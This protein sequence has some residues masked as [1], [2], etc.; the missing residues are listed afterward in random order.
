MPVSCTS[1]PL[2]PK[3]N[4]VSSPTAKIQEPPKA[5]QNPPKQAVASIIWQLA[6]HITLAARRDWRSIHPGA[7]VGVHLVLWVLAILVVPSLFLSVAFEL[8]QYTIEGDCERDSDS[9]GY[10]TSYS[11]GWYSFPTQGAADRYFRLLEALAAFAVLLLISHFTLFVMA[12]VET[13]R[14]RRYGKATK[15]VYLVAAPGPGADGR[16]YYTT[17]ATQQLGPNSRGSVLAPQAVHHHQ[18][19]HQQ[20]HV[21]PGAHGYYAP[22]AGVAPGTAA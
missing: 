5:D 3:K 19:Q 21:D 13:D 6:E 12:C 1:T 8:E 9:D 17:L 16:T 20:G 4:I 7:H 18:Q 22:P 2:P 15:V 11:C 14:R 10:Y